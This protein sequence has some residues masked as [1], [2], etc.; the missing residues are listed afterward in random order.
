MTSEKVKLRWFAAV[1][2]AGI[3]SLAVGCQSP[4]VEQPAQQLSPYPENKVWAVVPLANLSGDPKVE[5][6]G[7]AEDLSRQL[8]QIDRIDALPMATT[9][10]ALQAAGLQPHRELTDGQARQL[11]RL[12]KVDGLIGGAVTAMDPYDPPKIGLRIRLYARP[13]TEAEAASAPR[14]GLDY[15]RLL[16]AA[17][18]HQVPG[19]GTEPRF[20]AQVSHHFDAASGAVIQR[21]KNYA[22]GR[23]PT[24]SPSGWRRYLLSSD[25]FR[26]FVCHEMV[27]RLF[28]LE[29]D[30]QTT[31][32]DRKP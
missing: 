1:L 19:Q 6:N 32:E 9:L 14:T 21:L 29:W 5:T 30:R 25:L 26:E 11:M 31:V 18:A 23:V 17:S 28:D 22:R 12:L 4:G 16:T 20:V 10:E 3:L 2:K 27:R 24:D 15:R 13:L 7:F 8:R